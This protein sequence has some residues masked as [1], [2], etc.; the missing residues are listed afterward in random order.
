MRTLFIFIIFSFLLNLLKYGRAEEKNKIPINLIQNA[1]FEEINEKGIPVKWGFEGLEFKIE[2][3]KEKGKVIKLTLLPNKEYGAFFSS[4]FEIEPGVEYY[5]EFTLKKDGG[6]RLIPM[7][8]FW[9]GTR[10][11]RKEVLVTNFPAYP[12][13]INPVEEFKVFYGVVKAPEET[14]FKQAY[15]RFYLDW[16]RQEK[17]ESKNLY[18]RDIKVYRVEK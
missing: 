10:E 3:L 16:F 11:K 6:F 1:S 14:E 2:D 7:I 15:I 8:V 5:V 9:P 12:G 13:N 4:M 18:I 17:I